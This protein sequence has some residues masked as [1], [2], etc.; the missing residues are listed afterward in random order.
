MSFLNIFRKKSHDEYQSPNFLN[1]DNEEYNDD[2]AVYIEADDNENDELATDDLLNVN[3]QQEED[4]KNALAY[5]TN[6]YSQANRPQISKLLNKS[7]SKEAFC[8]DV[9][10]QLYIYDI[11]KKFDDKLKNEIVLKFYETIWGY[12]KIN[13]LLEDDSI[14]DIKIHS[15]DNIR[16]KQKGVRKSSD[17]K[18]A[19]VKEYLDFVGMIATKNK[20]NLGEKNAIRVFVDK[21]TCEKAR[22]RFNITTPFINSSEQPCVHIRKTL[23]TKYT[24]DDLIKEGMLDQEKKEYLIDKVKNS[25]GIIICGKGAA[26]KT[27]LMNALLSVIPHDKSGLVLQESEELFDN[28]HPDLMF[29][30]IVTNHGEGSIEYSLKDIAINGLL[31]D[32]DYYIIGEIKGNEAAYFLNASYTGHKCWCSVHGINSTE[33]LDKLADYITYETDY[34]R[35]EIMSMLKYMQTII[36]LEDFKIKEISEVS[37]YDYVSGQL[38]YQRIF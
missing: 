15:F 18:F 32:L 20:I 8:N 19:N 29:Q 31:L 3:N 9:R 38:I 23:T 10:N 33:A 7:I 13:P 28:E 2:S 11:R 25:T 17:I 16:I 21:N 35:S 12:S 34:S 26:G 36:F 4:I 22:L 27:V 30:H 6:Y 5:L 37:G 14:S 24:L 1:N